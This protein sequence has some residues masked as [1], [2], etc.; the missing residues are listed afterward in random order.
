MCMLCVCVC[1]SMCVY[2]CMCVYVTAQLLTVDPFVNR[3]TGL[4]TGQPNLKPVG[5]AQSQKVGLHRVRN[6]V[7]KLACTVRKQACTCAGW[8][9]THHVP[10]LSRAVNDH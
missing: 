4:L 1:A 5:G 8:L 3:S 6:W 2:E 9:R 10:R 7:N